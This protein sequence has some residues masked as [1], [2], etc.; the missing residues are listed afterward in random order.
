MGFTTTKKG[1]DVVEHPADAESIKK[2]FDFPESADYLLPR[3]IEKLESVGLLA[4]AQDLVQKVSEFVGVVLK[5]RSLRGDP[6]SADPACERT[7]FQNLQNNL[8]M[9]AQKLLTSAI[10]DPVKMDF[11]LSDM[12]QFLRGYSVNGNPLDPELLDPCDK[13]FNAW[14]AENNLLSKHGQIYET[15]DNGEIRKDAKGMPITADPDKIRTLLNNP[16][17][18][19][20]VYLGKKTIA[21]ITQEHPYPEEKPKVNPKVEVRKTAEKI[22]EQPTAEV[23]EKERIKPD[24]SSG[25]GIR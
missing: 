9:E 1:S 10:S 4:K 6:W 13:L 3:L 17:K 12:S 14:L 5:Q 11:A 24:D 2:C 7:D 25:A 16:A 22:P 20:Q 23:E 15:M 18:S 8:A 21:L 19:F